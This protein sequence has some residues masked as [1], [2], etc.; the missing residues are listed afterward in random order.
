MLVNAFL[1][2]P[3]SEVYLLIGSTIY[4]LAIYLHMALGVIDEICEF[5]GIRAFSLKTRLEEHKLK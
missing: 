1:G 4:I 2:A 3:V 5:L